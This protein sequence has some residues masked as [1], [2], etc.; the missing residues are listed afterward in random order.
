M[1]TRLKCGLI[2]CVAR[3]FQDKA[4]SQARLNRAP[5]LF[6]CLGHRA[7]QGHYRACFGRHP[8][9]QAPTSRLVAWAFSLSFPRACH[10]LDSARLVFALNSFFPFFELS[11][12]SLLVSFSYHSAL[13]FFVAW[14]PALY[15]LLCRVR[16]VFAVETAQC[17]TIT[18]DI[19]DLHTSLCAA[20]LRLPWC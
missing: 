3:P 16:G 1:A 2:D 6:Q 13:S 9:G 19:L 17:P 5:E 8:R 14:L 12:L 18:R 7:L 4:V 20:L 11:T 10:H 15:P